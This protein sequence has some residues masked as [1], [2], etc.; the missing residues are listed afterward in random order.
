ML[1]FDGNLSKGSL[2]G[3]LISRGSFYMVEMA[4]GPR[5]SKV[6]RAEFSNQPFGFS[7]GHAML[8][9]DFGEREIVPEAEF[10]IHPRI[11]LETF[12][13]PSP[14]RD[15]LRLMESFSSLST[16]E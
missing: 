7:L 10:I 3:G 16:V 4:Y 2:S 14:T 8:C 6:H 1:R 15:F 12:Q 11:S 13:Y 9:G 5:D